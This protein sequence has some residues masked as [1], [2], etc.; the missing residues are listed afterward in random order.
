MVKIRYAE[1]PAGLHVAIGVR[2]ADTVVYLQPGLTPEQRKQALERARRSA[3][4]GH[5][6]RL[7]ALGLAAAIGADRLRTTARAAAAVARRH[8]VLVLPLVVLAAGL[9]AMLMMAALG[10]GAPPR[11]G[12]AHGA[13][14]A[15][16]ARPAGGMQVAKPPD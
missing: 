10:H 4:L 7:P 14:G 8:P 5:A 11:H 13:R 12:P 6:P 1:L 16:A 15:A 3:R 2:D 9:V